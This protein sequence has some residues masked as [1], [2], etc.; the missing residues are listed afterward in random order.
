MSD[1]AI[2]LVELFGGITKL[3]S[4][5]L[6]IL[7]AF[8]MMVVICLAVKIKQLQRGNWSFVVLF[9]A[10]FLKLSI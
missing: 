9:A 3:T 8:L 4:V 7:T 6:G 2:F 10:S 5:I 1:S